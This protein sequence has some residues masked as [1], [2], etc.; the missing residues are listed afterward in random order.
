MYEPVWSLHRI[1]LL[2]TGLR[3]TEQIPVRT[4][5]SALSTILPNVFD[6]EFLQYWGPFCLSPSAT[7][8]ST[9]PSCSTT[10]PQRQHATRTKAG[11]RSETK[12]GCKKRCTVPRHVSSPCAPSPGVC[13]LQTQ[14]PG[15]SPCACMNQFGPCIA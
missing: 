10:K 6:G 9:R 2:S 3:H 5:R 11:Q 14:N 1:S 7:L 15:S 13:L 8:T 12:M 4:I